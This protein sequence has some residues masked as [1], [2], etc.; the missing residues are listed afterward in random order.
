VAEPRLQGAVVFLSRDR[1]GAVL[2]LL[3]PALFLTRAGSEPRP[4]GSGGVVVSGRR[5]RW[6][7][8]DC[9]E[10]LCF[11]AA[12]VRERTLPRRFLALILVPRGSAFNRNDSN[13][14]DAAISR[15]LV[16]ASRPG[17][18]HSSR[19][20][21]AD[22]LQ[23]PTRKSSGS[24]QAILP[25]LVLLRVGFSLPLRLPATRC[26]LTA[27]FHPYLRIRRS[28]G[29]IFSVALIRR[30]GFEPAPPAVNRHAALW[31]PDFA[32]HT[33]NAPFRKHSRARA[34]A[35]R[36]P[37]HLPFSHGNQIETPRIHTTPPRWAGTPVTG[38][39]N[40]PDQGSEALTESALAEGA[41]TDPRYPKGRRG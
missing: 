28:A 34:T 33:L 16:P 15:F 3:R 40:T 4:S 23:Q 25:Y 38:A 41:R 8:R 36:R 12:T 19:P 27:P 14:M 1:E 11:R 21:I 35:C 32:S 10:R 29:G 5:H 9:K 17:G 24:G 26:A 37:S 20:A 22:G 7:S 6:R 39:G 18:S 30:T 2:A 13:E 31:R